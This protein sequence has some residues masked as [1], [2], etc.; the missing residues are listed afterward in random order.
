MPGVDACGDAL[1]AGG[2]DTAVRDYRDVVMGW[3]VSGYRFG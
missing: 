1:G 2:N 3:V